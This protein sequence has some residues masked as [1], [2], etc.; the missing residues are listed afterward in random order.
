MPHLI[1]R[2]QRIH[3]LVA[4]ACEQSRA[5]TTRWPLH[6]VQA[7]QQI[8]EL[9]QQTLPVNTLMQRAGLATAQLTLAIAP[10]A[11]RIWI[12][13]GPGNNGGDGLEAAVHLQRWGKTPIVTCIARPD[14]MPTDAQLAWRRAESAGVSF[15][16][17]PPVAFDFALDALLGIGC[18]HPPQG[19]LAEWLRLL[20]QTS[21]GV[22]HID[23][24]SGLM[25]DTGEWLSKPSQVVSNSQRHTLSL[26]TLKPGL[27]T[28]EGRDACGQVWFNDLKTS[29]HILPNAWLQT[30][31]HLPN[32]RPHNSHKGSYGDVIVVG[33]AMG[34]AGAAVLAGLAALH[35]GAG[36]VF[37]GLLD[38]GV[39]AAVTASHPALM[40]RA[41][42]ALDYK[43]ATVVCGCGGG[44][45]V[46]HA[47]P[48]VLSTAPRLVLDADALNAL[49]NDSQ[50]FQ[51]LQQRANK[52]LMTVLTPHPLEAARLLKCSTSEV[53]CNRL[54]AAHALA[55]I[56]GCV[57]ALKGSGTVIAEKHRTPVINYSG[58]AKLATAG[59]GD[60]LAGLI[61]T[62]LANASD[63]F[64]ATCT[65]VYRHGALA[66]AWP[67]DG[68]N[69]TAHQMVAAIR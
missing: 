54:T 47:L 50:L 34:M 59:T 14:Q 57:V 7:T 33:G 11:Q 63:G 32:N 49:A 42:D 51:L 15:E 55:D 37:A 66:D 1:S 60:V 5:D 3:K 26:L 52:R 20:Q 53:Q 19:L 40:V 16:Q 43:H 39:H 65:A 17:T 35:A 41:V 46:R 8:E 24:P 4:D 30:H 58:D 67:P 21:Q 29:H 23:T 10:H 64:E 27:F 44:D 13:C 6:G 45:A 2:T 56:S 38:T 31:V 25:P 61:G 48:R 62:Q 36:R 9:A 18:H 22:L 69:L 28:A 12:A 68:P